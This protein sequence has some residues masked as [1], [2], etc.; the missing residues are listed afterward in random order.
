MSKETLTEL[1]E[2]KEM[3]KRWK[4]GQVTQEEHGVAIQSC[5]DRVRK[6]R[7]DLELSLARVVKGNKKEFNKSAKGRVGKI[8]THC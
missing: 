1:K 4:W 6:V 7:T 5:R 8:L 2:K 3:Y